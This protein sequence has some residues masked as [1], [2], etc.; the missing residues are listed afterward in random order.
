MSV[1]SSRSILLTV[2]SV[3]V[4]SVMTVSSMTVS[5]RSAGPAVSP[6]EQ[7]AAERRQTAKDR[8][9][10][11]P[12]SHHED[13]KDWHTLH[14]TYYDTRGRWSSS[15]TLNNKGRDAAQPEVTLFNPQGRAYVI[16]NVVVP[17]PASSRSTSRRSSDARVA[18]SKSAAY[19]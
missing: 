11:R 12:A 14:S 1:P 5:S 10:K 4:L 16:P 3:V 6:E 17:V 13:P 18:T 7:T 8:G 2:L 9:W 15:L 19:A